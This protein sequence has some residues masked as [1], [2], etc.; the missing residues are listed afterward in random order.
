MKAV[1]SWSYGC[2]KIWLYSEKASMKDMSLCPAVVSTSRS[3]WGKGKLSL[4]QVLLMS[5]KSMQTLYFILFFF[6]PPPCL[7][8]SWG[9]SPCVCITFSITYEILHL[10]QE[11]ATDPIFFFFASRVW[12]LHQNSAS[13]II[14]WDQ[15]LA[16]LWW[17][18]LTYLCWH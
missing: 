18:K 8:A 15:F 10:Q 11:L 3:I 13:M 1:F 14:F 2:I 16:C 4:W 6:L 17:T 9:T 5:V 7:P 12:S